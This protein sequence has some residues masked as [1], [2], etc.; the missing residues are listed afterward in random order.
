MEIAQVPVA[1]I[2][3]MVVSLMVSVALPLI[4]LIVWRKKTKARVSVF[5]IGAGTFI[6]F[7][8]ILEQLL[9]TVVVKLTGNLLLDN[10]WLY[11]LYGGLAAGVF[12]ETGRL[13]AMKYVVKKLDKK[14]AVM[15]GIGHG[16]IEAILISGLS[17]V[18]NL[19]TS[20]MINSGSLAASLDVLG[21]Q[22][23]GIIE[24][25][26]ALWTESSWMFYMAGVERISA[27]MIHIVMSY[28]VYLAVKQKKKKWYI[29][30][31]ILHA[32]ADGSMIIIAQ[33]L[34]VVFAEAILLAAC[35]SLV[36]V[37]RKLYIAEPV[38]AETEENM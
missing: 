17:M 35:V 11:A 20:I 23:E 15:Y 16:G 25:L 13:V 4:L 6:L 27:V 9:H 12:E 22:K 19:V 24:Q 28:M 31:V 21:D 7:A 29:S 36:L 26:S 37:V 33:Y 3:G 18:S 34:P 32:L 10:I 1:S 14:N 30:A 5:F 2:V 8:L 38:E